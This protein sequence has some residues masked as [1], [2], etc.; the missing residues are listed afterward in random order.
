M[1]CRNKRRVRL[2]T[3][4]SRRNETGRPELPMLSV[5]RDY[6]V[7]PREG[8][9]DNYNKPGDDL[10]AY[11]V[12]HVHDLVLNKMKTWQGSLGISQH[13]GLVSPAYFVAEPLTS[14]SP[15]FLHHLLRSQPLIAEYGARSKGIR[16]S[17][18]DLPWDEFRDIEVELPSLRTQCAVA[19]YLD[20]ETSRIDALIAAKRRMVGMLEERRSEEIGRA[21][22]GFASRDPSLSLPSW[23][24]AISSKWPLA[25]LGRCL[26]RA[27]Y[28]FTNPMPTVDDGPYLLTANDIGDGVIA[29][30]TARK[31]SEESYATAIT[32]KSRPRAG[33]V[34]VTKDGTLGR[35]AK[36]DGARACINQSVALLRPLDVMDSDYLVALLRSNPYQ[37]LMRFNA[38]GTTIKHIYVTRIVKMPVPVPSLP[39]QREVVDRVHEIDRHHQ[40]VV[41]GLRRSID[42]LAE[43]RRAVISEAVTGR[44]DVVEAA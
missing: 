1:I 25:A 39:D 36:S 6:G 17:Q 38:G 26:S 30:E 28:G 12:V 5:Y 3:I 15:R 37:E 19:E 18:W 32:D 43:R 7:I 31:T 29:Y 23:S 22:V 27:T 4:F 35:V 21:V 16:P 44:G 2:R 14:D 9:D 33:D 24:S 13:E 10:D 42:L 40:A 34:L 41:G 20:R 11:R 8:R